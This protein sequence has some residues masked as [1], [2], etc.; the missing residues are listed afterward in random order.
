MPIVFFSLFFSCFTHA[1]WLFLLCT[2]ARTHA[3]TPA[4]RKQTNRKKYDRPHT[5]NQHIICH[6]GISF[7]VL[8]ASCGRMNTSTQPEKCGSSEWELSFRFNLLIKHNEQFEMNPLNPLSVCMC[9]RSLLLMQIQI[10]PNNKIQSARFTQI[11]A[12]TKNQQ[13]HLGVCDIFFI[14]WTHSCTHFHCRFVC[15]FCLV[16]FRSISFRFV[17]FWCDVSNRCVL[18]VCI[19]SAWAHCATKQLTDRCVRAFVGSSSLSC[20]LSH[21]ALL[22]YT[23]NTKQH[24][25]LPTDWLARLRG[26]DSEFTRLGTSVRSTCTNHHTVCTCSSKS[27]FNNNNRRK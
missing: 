5:A 22:S 3:R 23:H 6:N 14:S 13:F 9:V 4:R 1:F 26:F 27:I 25:A 7:H 2:H 20:L 16:S 12:C 21:L 19:I 18:R 17:W 24:N 8:P 10:T 11:H 15:S